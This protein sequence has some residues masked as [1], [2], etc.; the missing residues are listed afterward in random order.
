MVQPA[1]RSR[2]IVFKIRQRDF[3]TRA[4]DTRHKL[5]ICASK[6]RRFQIADSSRIKSKTLRRRQHRHLFKIILF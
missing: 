6:S 4:F 3:V 5:Q 1:S 2:T